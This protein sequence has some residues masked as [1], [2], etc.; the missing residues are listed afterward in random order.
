MGQSFGWGGRV[1]VEARRWLV[2]LR[3]VSL[4]IRFG[5]G[6]A[7][8][9]HGA[10]PHGAAVRRAARGMACPCS[11]ATYEHGDEGGE[12]GMDWTIGRTSA[13]AM[14]NK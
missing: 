8:T 11:R 4:P 9:I 7:C 12:S 2:W 14:A 10:T 3:L 13:V 6:T 5:R 1:G